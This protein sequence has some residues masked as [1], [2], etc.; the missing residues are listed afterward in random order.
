MGTGGREQGVGRSK[1]WHIAKGK[2]RLGIAG[3]S[4]GWGGNS[5]WAKRV[6]C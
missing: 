6:K 2:Q 5:G 1:V 4:G 3:G